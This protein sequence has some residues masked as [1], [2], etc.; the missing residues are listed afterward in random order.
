MR[1]I[2]EKQECY[3]ENGYIFCRYRRVRNSNKVLD[4]R[5]YGYKAWRIPIKKH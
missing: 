3:K 4:A 5:E 1:K 2:I